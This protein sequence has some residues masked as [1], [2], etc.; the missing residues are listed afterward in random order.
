M[1]VTWGVSVNEI[2]WG[3]MIAI[4]LFLA[5]VAGG[6]FLTASLTD[7]FNKTKFTKVIRAGA[8]IAPIM[9]IIGLLLLVVDLGRPFTFWKLL[10]NVNFGSV[11][12]IGV[13]IVSGFSALSVVYGYLVWS[14]AAAEKKIQITSGNT[15][16][17]AA[18]TSK[19][20]QAFR[21]P[22]AVLGVIFSIGTASYTGFLLSAI[23]TNNFW[24]TPFL[25]IE[26][27][28]FL[29]I[30]FL[31]SAISTGL[32]ATLI[33]AYDCSD[34]TAYKKTDIVL[35]IIE[36]V[37]IS[38]LYLSVKPIYFTGSMTALFWLGVVTVGLMVPLLLSIYGVS[39]HKNLV[40]PVCGMVVI[41]GL[42]LRYFVVYT[43]QLF[44]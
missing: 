24:H 3:G 10:L 22:V 42:C 16:V 31:V 33:G 23:T 32:A 1:D 34:L 15:Q 5:G 8:Y 2:A 28:P 9:I 4:Y 35:L 30:L 36:I 17:A 38:I 18:S 43:G 11:M 29:P 39:K 26:A 37:L 12:S 6:A 20:I 27:I 14:S 40:V 7:L 19:G 41:G 44:R 13:F 21:K 25:G